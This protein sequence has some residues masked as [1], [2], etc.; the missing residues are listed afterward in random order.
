MKWILRS[1]LIPMLFAAAPA[2]AG[3]KAIPRQVRLVASR[4]SRADPIDTPV[5]LLVL[6]LTA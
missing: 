2:T 4:P 3:G 6:R 5:V 1:L